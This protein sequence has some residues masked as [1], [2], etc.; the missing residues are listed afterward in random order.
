MKKAFTLMEVIAVLVIIAII[1]LIA[2]PIV[3]NIIDKTEKSSYKRSV[4]RYGH[5]IENAIMTYKME[6]GRYATELSELNIEY[7]GYKV[8]CNDI[9]LNK[10]GTVYL[11][12]CYVNNKKVKDGNTES[13]WYEYGKKW[14]NS[15]GENY[16]YNVGDVIFYNDMKFYVM[17]NNFD[18]VTLL[19]AKPLLLDE[20]NE[21]GLGHINKYAAEGQ[22]GSS[23]QDVAFNF[24]GYGAIAY[25]TSESCGR[26]NG[27]TLLTGCDVTYE[28]SD[29]KY[30]L[31]NWS[32]E[33]LDISD[34]V[35]DE[36][37]YKI[38]LITIDELRNA[39][40]YRYSNIV[41]ENVPKW[42]YNSNYSYWT[43][44]SGYNGNNF[45]WAVLSDGRL[46]DALTIHASHTVRPVVNLKKEVIEG[47]S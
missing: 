24:N 39:F 1:A 4:D 27:T 22:Y 38:R 13:D 43:M 9:K 5:A 15:D 41:N 45:V 44:S 2:F 21:Y 20:I 16:E 17:K 6:N 34:L 14:H 32:V 25:Y 42:I 19:K 47:V 31:D 29:V 12:K 8:K 10:N 26:V 30:I 37:G 36:L 28:N 46:H 3:N 40:G 35:E 23:Y 18:Y 33:R 7:S 11:S